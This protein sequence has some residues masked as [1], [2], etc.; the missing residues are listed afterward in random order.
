MTPQKENMYKKS[1]T[2]FLL[3]L[4]LGC[5]GQKPMTRPSEAIREISVKKLQDA[6]IL[7]TSKIQTLKS[8]IIIQISSPNS[9]HP[10][11]LNGIFRLKQPNMMRMVA[12]RLTFTIFDMIYNGSQFWFYIPQEEKVYSGIF[13]D[14][15]IINVLGMLFKPHDIINIFN[16]KGLFEEKVASMGIEERH[17]VIHIMEKQYSGRLFCNIYIE[18]NNINVT[19][20]EFFDNDGH[21]KTLISLDNYLTVDGCN[22]PRMIKVEWLPVKT[23]IV[24]NLDG[25]EV[26]QE[27]SNNIFDFSIPERSTVV[28]INIW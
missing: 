5:A 22:V 7:N 10:V 20:C 25:L 18:K 14:N 17:W 4:I 16:Y 21:L 26:N 13:N 9:P 6:I 8:K 12:S 24:L 19:R 2:L 28:P 15:A 3:L 1:V 11:R 27:L 23:A